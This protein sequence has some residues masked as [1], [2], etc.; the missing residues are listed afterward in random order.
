MDDNGMKNIGADEVDIRLP[1]YY[2][3]I[4]PCGTTLQFYILTSDCSCTGECTCFF[5][6]FSWYLVL[7]EWKV[8][9][10][11]CDHGPVDPRT[12]EEFPNVSTHFPPLSHFRPL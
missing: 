2:N 6:V 4:G 1:R 12:I 5:F 3:S 11:H 10:Q 7:A 8:S 9:S